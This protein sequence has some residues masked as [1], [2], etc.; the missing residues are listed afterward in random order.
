MLPD[1]WQRSF[2]YVGYFNSFSVIKMWISQFPELNQ[3]KIHDQLRIFL[4]YV[5]CANDIHQWSQS[6]KVWEIHCTLQVGFNIPIVKYTTTSVYRFIDG[7]YLFENLN[8]LF[9]AINELALQQH[10]LKQQCSFA[11]K[12]MFYL[13]CILKQS[14]VGNLGV[15]QKFLEILEKERC[16]NLFS[17]DQKCD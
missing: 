2:I 7:A 3:F 13:L 5:F 1:I 9:T 14:W 6:V 15:N 16:M 17:P 4:K 10:M 11:Y 8:L 12:C